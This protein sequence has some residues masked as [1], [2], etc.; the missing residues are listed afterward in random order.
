MITYFQKGPHS[1]KLR[2]KKSIYMRFWSG[3]G[4]EYI[5]FNPYGSNG[6]LVN[7]CCPL[8]PFPDLF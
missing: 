1:E 3:G 8:D 7:P 6:T 2:F 4:G 5:Q